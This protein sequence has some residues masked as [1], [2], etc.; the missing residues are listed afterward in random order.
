MCGD[1]II[2]GEAVSGVLLMFDYWVIFWYLN[3]TQSRAIKVCGRKSAHIAVV[4][5]STIKFQKVGKI[6][7]GECRCQY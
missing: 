1:V 7:F 6:V 3:E 2:L 4:V 5:K